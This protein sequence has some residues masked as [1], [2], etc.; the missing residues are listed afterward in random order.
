MHATH[1][2]ARRCI[3]QATKENSSRRRKGFTLHVRA[4][5]RARAAAR[6]LLPISTAV[7]HRT[8]ATV[9]RECALTLRALVRRHCHCLHRKMLYSGPEATRRYHAGEMKRLEQLVEQLQGENI[10]LKKTVDKQDDKLEKMEKQTEKMKTMAATNAALRS[11][12]ANLLARA[13]AQ[14]QPEAA[15]QPEAAGLP[16]MLGGGSSR[17]SPV[18]RNLI[19][20]FSEQSPQDGAERSRSDKGS[21]SPLTP[22]SDLDLSDAGIDAREFWAAIA[23]SLTNP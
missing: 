14:P 13:R 7:L 2:H 23:R 9:P 6:A 1:S 18:A 4:E 10:R 5:R 16:Q 15:A 19:P 8:R 12:L 3:S 22:L 17:E 20:S 21:G 11:R